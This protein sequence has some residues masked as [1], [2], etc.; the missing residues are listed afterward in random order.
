MPNGHES[1][2]TPP[3][4]PPPPPKPPSGPGKLTPQDGGS[5]PPQPQSRLAVA[6]GIGGAVGG[7]I[8][9]LIGSCLHLH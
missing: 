3:P 2:K 7:L 1:N 9:A 8:G 5:L 6:A 4:P